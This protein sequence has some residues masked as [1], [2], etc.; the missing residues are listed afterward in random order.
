MPVGDTD[1]P[2][3]D[4]SFR[5]TDLLELR[6]TCEVEEIGSAGGLSFGLGSDRDTMKN[7]SDSF[8]TSFPEVFT[9]L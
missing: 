7:E 9:R 4:L 8:Q 2:K 6:A 3:P 5:F 1:T